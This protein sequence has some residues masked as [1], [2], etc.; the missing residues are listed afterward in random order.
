M[1][2]ETFA[3]N[4]NESISWYGLTSFSGKTKTDKKLVLI[5][6]HNEVKFNFKKDIYKNKVGLELGEVHIKTSFSTTRDNALKFGILCTR[7]N[8][9]VGE[10]RTMSQEIIDTIHVL[11]LQNFI[12]YGQLNPV[13]VT[14]DSNNIIERLANYK[15]FNYRFLIENLLFSS[16]LESN[17]GA[18]FTPCDGL[19]DAKESLIN[20]K[21]YKTLGVVYLLEI[22]NWNL[23]KGESKRLQAIFVDSEYYTKSSH[24][25]FAFTTKDVSA[26]FNFMVTLLDS[27]GNKITFPSN[28]T[29]VPTRGFKI[30]IVK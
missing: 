6:P 30:Q 20:S 3:T 21:I 8:K 22:K 10:K 19:S 7:K 2:T 1:I 29:K 9:I 4:L 26:L 27:S 12:N 23:I 24:F 28:E 15:K 13:A 5:S 14:L 16:N 18:I 17:T 11:G 25:V